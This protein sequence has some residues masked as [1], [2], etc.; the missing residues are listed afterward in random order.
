MLPAPL[1][2]IQS[3]VKIIVRYQ[4]EGRLKNEPPLIAVNVLL[5]PILFN[6]MFHKAN[7][8]MPAPALDLHEYIKAFLNGR[9]LQ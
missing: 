3:L 1:E 7:M 4:S 6:Q 9:K 8:D 5:A 2:N